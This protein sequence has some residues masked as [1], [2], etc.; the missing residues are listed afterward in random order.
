MCKLLTEKI[1]NLIV[2]ISHKTRKEM[3]AG[4]FITQIS[5]FQAV[6]LKIFK[7]YHTIGQYITQHVRRTSYQVDFNSN[8][9]K[10]YT[11]IKKPIQ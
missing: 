7:L 11:N 6:T 9:S 8:S 5:T 3:Y 2:N 4:P 10:Y 1:S